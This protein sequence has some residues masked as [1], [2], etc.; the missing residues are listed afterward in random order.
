MVEGFETAFLHYAEDCITSAFESLLSDD[1]SDRVSK[2]K[3]IESVSHVIR[4]TLKQNKTL[5]N[6]QDLQAVLVFFEGFV[7]RSLTSV[8]VCPQPGMPSIPFSP[9]ATQTLGSHRRNASVSSGFTFYPG[10]QPPPSH[11]PV[12]PLDQTLLPITLYISFLDM[13]RPQMDLCHFRPAVSILVRIVAV[14]LSPL[15]RLSTVPTPHHQ[16][17]PAEEAAL[18]QLFACLAGPYADTVAG[19]I[20]HLLASA[21]WQEALGAFR[22]VRLALRDAAVS[23]MALRIL[24]GPRFA[25]EGFEPT[26]RLVVTEDLVDVLESTHKAASNVSGFRLAKITK[27]AGQGVREWVAHSDAENLLEEAL[28]IVE[29]VMAEASDRAEEK[30]GSENYPLDDHEGRFVGTV[31]NEAVKYVQRVR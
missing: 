17:R 4:K 29:D 9:E 23:R 27:A 18:K 20:K 16:F 12:S 31:L 15:P 8:P 6:E 10:N 24:Q 22:V 19:H 5:Y 2:E 7:H 3:Y 30:A 21:N 1:N 26:G 25:V 14:H 28:G 13:Y 11:E